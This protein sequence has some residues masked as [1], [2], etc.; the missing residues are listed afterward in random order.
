MN[1]F[2]ALAELALGYFKGKALQAWAKLL[3]TMAFSAVASFFFVCG[4]VLVSTRDWAISIGTAMITVSIVVT[5]L[6]RHSPLSKGLMVVLPEAEAKAE[7][8]SN[9][10]VIQKEK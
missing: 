8:D 6:F 2:S 9:L 4:T 1:P 5:A 3:F 10:Q 7:I